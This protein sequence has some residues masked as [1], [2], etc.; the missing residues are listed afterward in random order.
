MLRSELYKVGMQRYGATLGQ[1]CGFVALSPLVVRLCDETGMDCNAVATD[2]VLI[3][4]GLSQEP[5]RVQWQ[6]GADPFDPW[7]A[8]WVLGRCAFEDATRY[9]AEFETHG[10]TAGPSLW[11]A[12]NLDYSIGSGATMRVLRLAASMNSLGGLPKWV[13][14]FAC[15]ATREPFAHWW[16][17][18]DPALAEKRLLRAVRRLN[19]AATLGSLDPRDAGAPSE[20]LPAGYSPMPEVLSRICVRL[21]RL[22]R[23]GELTTDEYRAA[24]R[25]VRAYARTREASAKLPTVAWLA[26]KTVR[27][28]QRHPD[29]ASVRRAA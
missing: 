27:R 1:H 13:E 26:A 4:S 22:R 17:R 18:C 2:P 9:L 11:L 3:E 19:D 6:M 28:V 21:E 20:L 5:L 15:E 12:V 7:S 16:G 10:L 23:E 8:L 24:W 29:A 14:N 25:T